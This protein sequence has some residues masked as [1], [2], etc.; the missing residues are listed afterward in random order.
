MHPFLPLT[1]IFLALQDQSCPL[2]KLFRSAISQAELPRHCSSFSCFF[3]L[4]FHLSAVRLLFLTLNDLAGRTGVSTASDIL[5]LFFSALPFWTRRRRLD[6][7]TSD[8]GV[9]VSSNSCDSEES[10]LFLEFGF[11]DTSPLSFFWLVSCLTTPATGP[12][13][14]CTLGTIQLVRP[15]TVICVILSPFGKVV[16]ASFLP[17]P[18]RCLNSQSSGNLLESPNKSTAVRHIWMIEACSCFIC[19]ELNVSLYCSGWSLAW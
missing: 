11:W 18:H 6:G 16:G 10:S 9:L 17:L 15:P 1:L 12:V 2:F 5:S 14:F 19:A 4:A 3:N 13:F 8:S 7:S